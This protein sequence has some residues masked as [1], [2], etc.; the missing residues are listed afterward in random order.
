MT[1]ARLDKRPADVAAMFDG[2]RGVVIVGALWPRLSEVQHFTL[3][4]LAVH[5]ERRSV[6]GRNGFELQAPI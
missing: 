3:L 2:R 5:L 1:R 6:N 4:G